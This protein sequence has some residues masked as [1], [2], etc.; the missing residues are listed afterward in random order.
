[1]AF[2]NVHAPVQAPDAYIQKYS[3]IQD[4]TRRT[5]AA[6]VD[7]MDEAVGNLTRAFK[8][9]GLWDDT[10]TVFSTDNGG[11]HLGGGYNWPLRG[12]KTHL[13]EGGVRGAGFVHGEMLQTK[14]TTTRGL[15]HVSDW[16]PTLLHAAGLTP[17][18]GLDGVNLWETIV[19]G[20]P[21]P[22]KEILLNIDVKRGGGEFIFTF[23]VVFAVV[24]CIQTRG[25]GLEFTF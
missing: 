6:M 9:A 18:G 10:L 22:R 8:T 7:I 16:Y 11:T 23:H 12:E 5:H 20:A 3:F 2:Q 13:W 25:P 1:M 19:N 14:G 17:E 4:E 24:V 21:S 15:M